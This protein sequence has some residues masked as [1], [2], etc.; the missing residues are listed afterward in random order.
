M[1]NEVSY[2]I[3]VLHKCNKCG[4]ER[5]I[6][7]DGYDLKI[8]DRYVCTKCLEK[9]I[10]ENCGQM[11]FTMKSSNVRH[12]VDSDIVINTYKVSKRGN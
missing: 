5:N 8:F 2:Q 6:S 7:E 12:G 10:F 3:P 1:E 11:V 4:Y 9:F